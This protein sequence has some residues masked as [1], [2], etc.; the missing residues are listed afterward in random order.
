MMDKNDESSG[1]ETLELTNNKKV[2]GEDDS[3]N[4]RITIKVS[5][6]TRDNIKYIQD[7]MK[8]TKN[9]LVKEILQNDFKLSWDR[10]IS[11]GEIVDIAVRR[12]KRDLDSYLAKMDSI[13]GEF[14]RSYLHTYARSL[15]LN[16]C[17]V[18]KFLEGYEFDF[19]DIKTNRLIDAKFNE[20]NIIR[21][22]KNKIKVSVEISPSNISLNTKMT[23]EDKIAR[24]IILSGDIN[25][26]IKLYNECGIGA[27]SEYDKN[28]LT[29]IMS[30][31]IVSEFIKNGFS[32]EQVE[33]VLEDARLRYY[34]YYHI[35]E[36]DKYTDKR[37][38]KDEDKG[39]GGGS[40][41]NTYENDNSSII[42]PNNNQ[43]NTYEGE[44]EEGENGLSM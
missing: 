38:N 5:T 41:H 6:H 15:E 24:Y 25:K 22:N 7:I 32:P 42:P 27:A 16:L 23:I 39:Y 3:S 35:H 8:N 19:S 11:L 21:Q 31:K 10:Y 14:D 20:Y 34:T 9:D 37:H 4:E 36:K 44:E 28:G 30:E 29:P 33:N 26:I 43:E 18:K 40:E 17:R 12:F 2:N 1:K 13:I